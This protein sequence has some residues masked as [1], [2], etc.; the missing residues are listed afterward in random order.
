MV[1]A[2]V[3]GTKASAA[4]PR[5]AT[6]TDA[7]AEFGALWL[8]NRGIRPGF[9]AHE[10]KAC[11]PYITVYAH[12]RDVTRHDDMHLCLHTQPSQSHTHIPS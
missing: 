12:M 7:Q 4:T 5:A 11:Q 3:P 10:D 9:C 6:D 8:P 2:W 1:H